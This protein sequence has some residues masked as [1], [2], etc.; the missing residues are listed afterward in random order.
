MPGAKRPRWKKM[1]YTHEVEI[2][3]CKFRVSGGL[4]GVGPWV[5]EREC[6][7][8]GPWKFVGSAIDLPNAKRLAKDSLTS[9][10]TKSG[11]TEQASKLWRLGVAIGTMI[12]HHPPTC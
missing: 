3:K 10:L 5:V 6:N 2:G 11:M 8:R 4:G 1:G 7:G 9:C 12:M